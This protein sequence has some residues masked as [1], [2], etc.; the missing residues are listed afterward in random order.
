MNLLS[1]A[2]IDVAAMIITQIQGYECLDDDSEYHFGREKDWLK[3]KVVDHLIVADLY[4]VSAWAEEVMLSDETAKGITT[5]NDRFVVMESLVAFVE[6]EL[7]KALLD[8]MPAYVQAFFDGMFLD[9]QIKEEKALA[10]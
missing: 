8:Y 2:A 7:N 3:S 4:P 10:G 1:E 5:T 6:D 9:A